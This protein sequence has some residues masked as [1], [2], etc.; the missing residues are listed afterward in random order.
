M[1]NKKA[2]RISSSWFLFEGFEPERADVSQIIDNT[3]PAYLQKTLDTRN[4]GGGIQAGSVFLSPQTPDSLK[5]ADWTP[6]HSSAINPPGIA[7]TA[8]IPGILGITPIDVLP[9]GTPVRFQLS[10][11]G[12]G[13]KSG[14][15]MEVVAQFNAS[16]SRVDNTTLIAGPSRTD[17][18]KYVVWTFHPGDPSPMGQEITQS[19]VLSHFP[20]SRGTVEDAID[21]GF[22]FVKRVE[23]LSEG[24]RRAILNEKSLKI[25]KQFKGSA[26]SRKA[27]EKLKST[28]RVMDPLSKIKTE[29]GFV[30]LIQDLVKTV[31][32]NEGMQMS[33][34]RTWDA[35]DRVK[36]S[37]ELKN[38]SLIREYVRGVIA[39]SDPATTGTSSAI[40]SKVNLE[41]A[42]KGLEDAIKAAKSAQD[43]KNSESAG[44]EKECES[45]P[46]QQDGTKPKITKIKSLD[47][48][49]DKASKNPAIKT[50]LNKLKTL[51]PAAISKDP[52]ALGLLSFVSQGDK[53]GICRDNSSP[54]GDNSAQKSSISKDDGTT[55][56][57]VLKNA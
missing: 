42:K 46:T 53:G 22:N 17:P 10:H 5:S 56:S 25:S 43:K 48:A 30:Q 11:G 7:F 31:M 2:R 4:P 33:P 27:L 52:Q 1:L 12:A 34:R 38:E 6:L 39:E 28:D 8:P 26:E 49:S 35:L 41:P 45:D 54:K 40:M 55:T 19:T 29:A 47:A 37:F 9:P 18:D 16:L 51:S 44:I 21:L 32:D 3:D 14:V 57:R 36:K 24:R 13:G 15:S 20:D 50:A 23:S